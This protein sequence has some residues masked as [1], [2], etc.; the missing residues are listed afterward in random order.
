MAS[1]FDM[2]LQ[3]PPKKG[4]Q[5]QPVSPQEALAFA[6]KGK[7]QQR[8]SNSVQFQSKVQELNSSNSEY[9][10]YKIY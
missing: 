2:L 6:L 5:T 3:G 9:S 10:R 7:M 4:L 1:Y 8:K